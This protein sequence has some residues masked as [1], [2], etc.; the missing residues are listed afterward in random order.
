MIGKKAEDKGVLTL[1]EVYEVLKERKK[2][3]KPLTYEQQLAYEYTEKFKLSG[4][5]AEKALKELEALGLS[6]QSVVKLIEVMPKNAAIIK[7]IL[8]K[9]KSNPGEDVV[10]KV[11]AIT[12]NKG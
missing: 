1:D 8:S 11:L 9:D 3:S 10:S 12:N 4:K 5:Q 2:S 7:Q 6:R